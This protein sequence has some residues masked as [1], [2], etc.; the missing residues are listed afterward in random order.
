VPAWT[1]ALERVLTSE[2]L[3]ARLAAAGPARARSFTWRSCAERTLAV[4]REVLR[5]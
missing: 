4:Y 5:A 1:A 3:R 2:D